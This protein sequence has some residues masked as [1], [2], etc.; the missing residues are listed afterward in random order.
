[1]VKIILKI[2]ELEDEWRG[3]TEP[4]MTF[5]GNMSFN[6]LEGQEL[7]RAVSI[8]KEQGALKKELRKD[9]GF[10]KYWHFILFERSFTKKYLLNK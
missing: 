4:R 8:T 6:R 10:I 9:I 3:L 7:F 5:T 2:W 1:M